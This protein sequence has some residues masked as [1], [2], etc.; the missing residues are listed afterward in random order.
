MAPNLRY[1]PDYIVSPG[2]VLEE[3]LAE[4]GMSKAELAER[5]GRP[6]KTISEILHG[7]AAITP[8]RSLD[9]IRFQLATRRLMSL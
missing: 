1:T 7:K 9:F 6:N 4:L 3:Y 2:S 8:E 5:C